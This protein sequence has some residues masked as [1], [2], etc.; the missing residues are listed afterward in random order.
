M[1]I[2]IFL[3]HIFIRF[4]YLMSFLLCF[5]LSLNLLLFL[6]EFVLAS[7][8]RFI[9]LRYQLPFIILWTVIKNIFDKFLYML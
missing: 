3:Q 6:F 1:E 5:N 4:W 7:F 9:G 8:G 2:V